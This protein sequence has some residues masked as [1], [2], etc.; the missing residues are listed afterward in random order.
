MISPEA[1]RIAKAIDET[2]KSIQKIF[3]TPLRQSDL[4]LWPGLPMDELCTECHEP[5]AI[6]IMKGTGLCSELCRKL[7]VGEITPD[8]WDERRRQRDVQGV[9]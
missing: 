2:M 7:H 4:V 8:Q 1:M 6:Q 5:V 3:T 9:Q